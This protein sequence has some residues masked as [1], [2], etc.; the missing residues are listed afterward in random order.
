MVE[1]PGKKVKAAKPM[2]SHIK[3]ARHHPVT[4]LKRWVDH[5]VFKIDVYELRGD[6]VFPA[7]PRDPR[8]K[9]QEVSSWQQVFA[10]LG[11]PVI[12]IFLADGRRL[13]LSDKH[14]DLRTILQE[15]AA[16]KE[17]PWNAI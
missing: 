4:C 2:Q 14:E 7:R 12:V 10:C 11:V 5:N 17:L 1:A 16:S 9:V 6:E 8:F 13:E 15:V 3:N